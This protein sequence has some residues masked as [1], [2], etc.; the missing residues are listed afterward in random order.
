[1][2]ASTPKT[3]WIWST[4]PRQEIRAEDQQWRRDGDCVE[5]AGRIQMGEFFHVIDVGVCSVFRLVMDTRQIFEICVYM[6]A[7]FELI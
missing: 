5:N 7:C 3:L 1:M 6:K 2:S 4:L